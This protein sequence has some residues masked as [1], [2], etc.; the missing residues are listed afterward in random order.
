M[1][2]NKYLQGRRRDAGICLQSEEIVRK[3][4]AQENEGREPWGQANIQ[5]F[6]TRVLFFPAICGKPDLTSG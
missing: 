2:R 4:N 6:P 5:S 1:G 3:R